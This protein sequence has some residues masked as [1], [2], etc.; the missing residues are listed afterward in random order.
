MEY[1]CSVF[2]NCIGSK[3]STSFFGC[4]ILLMLP[5]ATVHSHTLT[6]WDNKLRQTAFS[7]QEVSSPGCHPTTAIPVC[8]KA[9]KSQSPE[10]VSQLTRVGSSLR[11][12]LINK[13][14]GTLSVR[15]RELLQS[16]SVCVCGGEGRRERE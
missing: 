7:T 12:Y 13:S 5:V 2:A 14:I 4:L 1:Q 3:Y 8:Q 9:I 16:V 15:A 6:V 11:P 10:T